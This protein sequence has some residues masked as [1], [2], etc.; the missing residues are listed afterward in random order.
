MIYSIMLNISIYHR[1]ID[2]ITVII[3]HIILF[4]VTAFVRIN[5]VYLTICPLFNF[6]TL[7]SSAESIF[8]KNYFR[9]TIRVS[10]SLDQD[11]AGRSVGPDLGPNCLQKLSAGGKEYVNV[12]FY[13]FKC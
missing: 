8:S 4:V 5:Y 3:L 11:Q 2:H 12:R 9:N 6:P 1:S 10:D 7:L 13:S